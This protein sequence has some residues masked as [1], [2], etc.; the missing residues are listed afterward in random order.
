MRTRKQVIEDRKLVF[1]EFPTGRLGKP[2]TARSKKEIGIR[3]S[4][5][6]KPKFVIEAIRHFVGNGALESDRKGRWT[7]YRR[8]AKLD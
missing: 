3:L 1:R 8:P 6:V 7:S 4:H 2:G 5:S